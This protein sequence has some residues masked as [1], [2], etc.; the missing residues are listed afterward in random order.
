MRR[1]ALACVLSCQSLHCSRTCKKWAFIWHIF[2][3]NAQTR[4]SMRAVSPEPSML[5]HMHKMGVHTAYYFN[6]CSDAPEYAHSL[7]RSFVARTLP[8][9]M[10]KKNHQT[11]S[12]HVYRSNL[13][14]YNEYQNCMRWLKY[15]TCLM[16]C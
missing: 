9:W 4:L 8:K 16:V 15:N 14:I 7:V 13:Y 2:S 10:L 5:S 6:Q 3:V 12:K 11:K 1:R